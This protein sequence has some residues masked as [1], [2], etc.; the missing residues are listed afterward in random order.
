MSADDID[1]SS[2]K[3]SSGSSIFREYTDLITSMDL[4][5][6]E[7]VC[8]HDELLPM[9]MGY[10][11]DPDGNNMDKCSYVLYSLIH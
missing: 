10:R 3:D 6:S 4:A 8:T 5:D 7:M 11:A 1:A 2:L 9:V